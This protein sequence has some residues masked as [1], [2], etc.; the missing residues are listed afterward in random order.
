MSKIEKE[1]IK[2]VLISILIRITQCIAC[3]NIFCLLIFSSSFKLIILPIIASIVF[4]L[5]A[6]E[7]FNNYYKKRFFYY[8][9]AYKIK[10]AHPEIMDIRMEFK[11]ERKDY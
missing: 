6:E 4:I 3:I 11:D 5:K 8:Y 2:I 7:R 9:W 1:I 10:K